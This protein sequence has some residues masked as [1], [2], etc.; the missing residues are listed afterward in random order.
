MDSVIWRTS[1]LF[2]WPVVIEQGNVLP[3]LQLR[4]LEVG[5]TSAPGSPWGQDTSVFS[6]GLEGDQTGNCS[7]IETSLSRVQEAT[8]HPNPR[9]RKICQPLFWSMLHLLEK[10]GLPSWAL[11]LVLCMAKW[12]PYFTLEVAAFQEQSVIK[13]DRWRV[14]SVTNTCTV[15]RELFGRKG[16]CKSKIITI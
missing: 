2:S 8:A 3:S 4:S 1:C 9:H 5:V 11:P 14:I 15:H 7:P 10:A 12:G 13:K 6:L 16:L